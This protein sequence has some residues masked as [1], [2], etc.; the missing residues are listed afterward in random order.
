V[1]SARGTSSSRT[2][3]GVDDYVGASFSIARVT[4]S[5]LVMSSSRRGAAR[6]GVE[7]EPGHAPALHEAAPEPP[8]TSGDQDPHPTSQLGQLHARE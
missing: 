7:L 8:G 3:L 6:R 4:L 5:E 2:A 1:P